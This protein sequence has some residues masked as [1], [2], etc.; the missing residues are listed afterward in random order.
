MSDR[1]SSK[2]P[3]FQFYPG[4]WRKDPGV[5]ALT[6]EERGVWI[7]MLCLMHESEVRGKLML[8]GKPYPVDRLAKL[9]GLSASYLE[10][11]IT[12][13]ITLNVAS[14]CPE[15][16]ALINRRMVRDTEISQ[17]RSTTG[18]RG[19]NPNFAKGKPNPYYD[20]QT[21]NQKDNQNITPSSSS[22]SS[23]S[24]NKKTKAK[25]TFTKPTIDEVR[26]Y[27][28][29]RQNGIN[30]ETWMA[31]YEANGWKV[32]RNPMKDWRAAVRTWEQN[33]KPKASRVNSTEDLKRITVADLQ[34]GRSD[35]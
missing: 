8:G 14:R 12:S 32:G 15:T 23:A 22:S 16:G 33:H 20:N 3:A 29:E 6:Y 28:L 19:G 11:I 1:R 18:K 25:E 2:L 17:V 34:G 31:H 10:V 9:L 26:A 7:E 35:G 13:L 21:H 24:A 27:C 5:Q 30:A 4:D